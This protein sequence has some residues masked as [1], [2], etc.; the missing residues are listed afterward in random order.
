MA[1]EVVP[2]NLEFHVCYTHV[3]VQFV[4]RTYGPAL[5]EGSRPSE[6]AG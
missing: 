5:M 1:C 3:F 6:F 2:L 4:L